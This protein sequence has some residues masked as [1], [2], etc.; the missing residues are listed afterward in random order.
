M[1]VAQQLFRPS[2]GS[3]FSRACR[4]YVRP[5]RG[6]LREAPVWPAVLRRG[7]GPVAVFLP[8]TG[9]ETSALLRIYSIAAALRP[10]GWRTVI[11]P[12]GLDLAQRQR[13]IQR[14]GPDVLVM[15]GA[16]HALNRPMLY[17]GRRIVY[18]MDDADFHLPHLA[19]PV[20]EAM[21]EVAAVIAGS[22][23]V[24]DWCRGQGAEAHVVWTGAPVSA[25]P[26][27]AH[28]ARP[29]VVAWAQGDPVSYVR[30]R[31]FVEDVM[32][33]VAARRPGAQLRLYGR[34]PGQGDDILVPF[35]AMGVSVEW[36]PAMSY[37]RFLSALDDVAVGL[38]PICPDN[39]FSRGKSFGKV[40]AYLD[41]GVPVVASDEADHPLFFRPG[42]GVVSNEAA[43][44]AET[45]L[46]LLDDAGARQAM[47]DR[48]G[49]AFRSGLSREAAACGVD[50]VMRGVLDGTVRAERV[51]QAA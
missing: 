19:A 11:L 45:V 38:S 46:A 15:Q 42:M 47:A 12:P 3:L 49:E 17:P 22:R 23:Y 32:S 43:T 6:F 37:G 48:A 1:N 10:L 50:R 39:P 2:H 24:A 25:R 34:Q 16:R 5:L 27:R 29:S 4:S 9:P 28:A 36:L 8:A 21:P 30:E 14:I 13:L 26:W 41:R 35:R 7:R 40:L 44:W 33:R 31:A 20:T 18:D 51:L